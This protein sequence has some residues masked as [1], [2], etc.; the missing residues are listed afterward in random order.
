MDYST[1]SFGPVRLYHCAAKYDFTWEVA[2]ALQG[3]TSLSSITLRNL[4]T[5]CRVFQPTQNPAG[6]ATRTVIGNA[7]ADNRLTPAN[8]W[9]GRAYT[10]AL[11]PPA[12]TVDYTVTFAGSAS[13]PQK[14]A[15]F[16]PALLNDTY[17]GWYRII[18]NI[19]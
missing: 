7:E 16:T 13:R 3:T 17:T 18:A 19:E 10:Y 11:Q 1:L 2:A 9:I 12:G 6:T 15:S 14:E 8:Q 5:T 4:P